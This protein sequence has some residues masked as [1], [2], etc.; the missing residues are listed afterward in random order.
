MEI[1]KLDTSIGLG[2]VG[3]ELKNEMEIYFKE[4]SDV[5]KGDMRPEVV[6]M[7]EKYQMD[8]STIIQLTF[9]PITT[10]VSIGYT[11]TN[12]ADKLGKDVF[13]WYKVTM[14]DSSRIRMGAFIVDTYVRLGFV[15]PKLIK[16][17]TILNRKQSGCCM[18][19]IERN[20]NY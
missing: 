12:L 19:V 8:F 1:S 20:S 5:P 9:L 11:Y 17:K 14:K 13:N 16:I 3:L 6:R 2:P 7:V 10:S 15:F 18:Q 4:L